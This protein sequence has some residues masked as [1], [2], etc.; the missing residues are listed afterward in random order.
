MRGG[1]SFP[2]SLS[3]LGALSEESGSTE[4][5]EEGLGRRVE[6]A[7]GRGC[8]GCLLRAGDRMLGCGRGPGKDKATKPRWEEARSR[9]LSRPT[10]G[11]SLIF[12]LGWRRLAYFFAKSNG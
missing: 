1:S 8:S 2:L 11:L 12:G 4:V 6:S 3:L 9:L 5:R 7:G 10:A